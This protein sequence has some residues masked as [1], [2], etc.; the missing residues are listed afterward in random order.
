MTNADSS[1]SRRDFLAAGVGALGAAIAA[2]ALGAAVARA[3]WTTPRKAV[4]WGMIQTGSTVLEK[5]QLAKACGFEGIE[6]DAPGGPPADEIMEA[7]RATGVVIHGVVD[8]VHWSKTLGDPDPQ[9]RAAGLEG[10][11]AAIKDCKAYGGGSV[12]LV[13]AVVNEQIAYADA[14]KRSQE[15]IRKAVPLAAELGVKISM[16][17]V[18]NSFLLSPIE[19]ARYVDEF[20]SPVVGWHFD[21]GNV[22]NYGWPEQWI[23]TLGHRIN[24]LHV[25]EYSRKKRNDEGLWKGFNVEIGEGDCGWARVMAA[26]RDIGYE[27]WAT[28]EVGGG[29]ETRLRDVSQR[30]DRV[31]AL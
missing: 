8:S 27:G 28:A 12:L 21:V 18:W 25:K 26:I 31:F 11:R 29:D 6:I 4:G 24:R 16:E 7:T 22:V 19:A 14:Y 10:L 5:F 1:F 9:V 30:M 23:R 17:N 13:P 3:R 20:E 15:E 2:P